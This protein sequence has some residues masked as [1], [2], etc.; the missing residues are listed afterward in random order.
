MTN[1]DQQYLDYRDWATTLM[2]ESLNYAFNDG[3]IGKLCASNEDP[4]WALNIKKGILS[5]L[6]S[7]S[8]HDSGMYKEVSLQL[9]VLN[10]ILHFFCFPYFCIYLLVKQSTRFNIKSLF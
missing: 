9:K 1:P 2:S 4:E 3:K 7:S 6:Q 10:I 5:S 8:S